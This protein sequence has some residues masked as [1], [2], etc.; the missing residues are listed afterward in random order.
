MRD[1]ENLIPYPSTTIKKALQ[2]QDPV[3]ENEKSI[4]QQEKNYDPLLEQNPN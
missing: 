3:Y 4:F 1:R 2:K